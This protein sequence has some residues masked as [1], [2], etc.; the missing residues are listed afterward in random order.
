M[1]NKH[2]KGCIYCNRTRKTYVDG[3]KFKDWCCLYSNTTKKARSL[4]IRDN[5]K[6]EIGK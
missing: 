6:K 4:C 1:I 2:C 3:S 5:A